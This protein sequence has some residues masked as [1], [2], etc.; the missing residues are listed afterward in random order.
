MAVVSPDRPVGRGQLVLC[1]IG[2]R[3]LWRPF[4]VPV[5]TALEHLSGLIRGP[6]WLTAEPK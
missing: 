6:S 3:E 2:L 1:A 5:R 4:R